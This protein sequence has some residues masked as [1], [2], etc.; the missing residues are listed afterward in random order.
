MIP[1]IYILSNGRSGSTLLDLLLG[2]H[3]NIWTL[4]EAHILP[5][6]LKENRLPCGCGAQVTACEFWSVILPQIPLSASAYPI[7][8]F[9]EGH[10]HG[11]ALRWA[12]I[13]DIFR[14][15]AAGRWQTGV[16][17]YGAINAQYFSV[18]QSAAQRL[19]NRPISWLVDASKDVYRLFWLQQSGHFDLHIIHL[20]KDPRAFVFSATKASPYTTRQKCLRFTARWIFENALHSRLCSDPALSDKV[21]QLR[22]EELAKRPEETMHSLG[23]WLG[24]EPT[25]FIIKG[26][27]QEENHAVAGNLMRWQT[28]EIRLDD[29]WRQSLPTAEQKVIWAMCSPLART[30]HYQK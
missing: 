1:V 30:Y 2:T 26:F 13:V 12:H 22:Y 28:A 3:P 21:Y 25:G 19:T 5:W 18:V 20:T 6:E 16:A 24:V 9:R 14:H 10:A 11:R 4:G 17:T 7:E 8:Y 15:E 29:R 23:R 27:R